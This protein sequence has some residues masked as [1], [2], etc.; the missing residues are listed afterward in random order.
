[1]SPTSSSHA[2]SMGIARLTTS[3]PTYRSILPGAPPTYPKSASAISP[4]PFTMQ[5]ITA[6]AT[7]GRWPVRAAISAVTVC[8]SKSVRPQ[9]GHET[10]SVL[11]LRMREPCSSAKESGRRSTCVLGAETMT[12]SPSPSTSSAP[13]W[14][15]TL[16]VSA[17]PLS[18]SKTEARMAGVWHS[19]RAS[20]SKTRRLP[21]TRES[22]AAIS[23]ISMAAST[24]ASER[25]AASDSVPSMRTAMRSAPCGSAILPP[26]ATT[27]TRSTIA[28]APARGAAS[29]AA[30]L[31]RMPMP[32]VCSRLIVVLA[33]SSSSAGSSS[34]TMESTVAMSLKGKPTAILQPSAV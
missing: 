33:S 17:S 10:N 9:D 27:S 8:R 19:E 34:S 23:R 28:T 18:V 2:C 32:A 13:I 24:P 7:P 30:R 31:A 6:M 22:G 3:F 20:S 21:C 25:T 26:A 1:M 29:R 4:G 14:I 16:M 12:P 5:P 11:V 15:P